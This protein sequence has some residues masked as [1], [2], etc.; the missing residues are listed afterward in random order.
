[1]LGSFERSPATGSKF[2][3]GLKAGPDINNTMKSYISKFSQFSILESESADILLKHRIE[4]AE[5]GLADGRLR[6][7][8]VNLQW[9]YLP[10]TIS[11]VN[12]LVLQQPNY[13]FIAELGWFGIDEIPGFNGAIYPR[14]GQ[15]GLEV[16]EVLKIH[17]DNLSA[18]DS[19][20]KVKAKE[21]T[22]NFGIDYVHVISHRTR[23][24]MVRIGKGTRAVNLQFPE[25]WWLAEDNYGNFVKIDQPDL[26]SLEL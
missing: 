11:F 20:I 19:F 1:L 24:D 15:Q 8:I 5:L 23:P 10:N 14:A 12:A 26:K 21:A 2:S 7:L 13:K 9:M 16:A 18:L 22:V 17:S 3:P 4:L 6:A 25:D